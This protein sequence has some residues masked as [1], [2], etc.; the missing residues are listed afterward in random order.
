MIFG[1]LARYPFSV[2]ATGPTS[3]RVMLSDTQ[4]PAVVGHFDLP[5]TVAT[6]LETVLAARAAGDRT[7]PKGRRAGEGQQKAPPALRAPAPSQ[8]GVAD[9]LAKLADLHDKGV[10]ER[11]GVHRTEGEALVVVEKSGSAWPLCSGTTTG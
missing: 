4:D 6:A 7:G 2:E 1:G 10:L 3:C 11:R 5:T 8:L 9:E